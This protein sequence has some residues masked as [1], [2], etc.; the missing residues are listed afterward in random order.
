MDY[1]EC[2]GNWSNCEPIVEE[3]C[4]VKFSCYKREIE[5]N[6]PEC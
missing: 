6:E 3:V 1:P 2:F 4:K 5:K